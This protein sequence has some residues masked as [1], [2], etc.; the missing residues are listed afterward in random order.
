MNRVGIGGWTYEPWRGQFFLE[1][2]PKAK[3]LF[4]ASRRVA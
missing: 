2:L 3:E 4:H 1:K